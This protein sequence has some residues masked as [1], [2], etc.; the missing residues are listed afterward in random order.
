MASGLGPQGY[1]LGPSVPYVSAKALPM[2]LMTV[3]ENLSSR[4]LGLTPLNLE[5]PNSP[6]TEPMRTRL[7]KSVDK[8]GNWGSCMGYLGG[9]LFTKSP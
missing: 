2:S 9:N 7:S 6:N 3:T 1:C 8:G 4:P 5:T